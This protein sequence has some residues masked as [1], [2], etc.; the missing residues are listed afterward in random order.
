MMMIQGSVGQ[1]ASS[2]PAPPMAG[3]QTT[4]AGLP[5]GDAADTMDRLLSEVPHG[6]TAFDVIVLSHLRWNFVFQRPQH[7]LSRCARQHRVFFVE[8]PIETDGP[9]SMDISTPRPG[10]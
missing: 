2:V 5:T 3:N 7:L 4:R 10:V 1:C 9:A 8:E 6:H